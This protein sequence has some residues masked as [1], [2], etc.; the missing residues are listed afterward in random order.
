EN[1]SE[2]FKKRSWAKELTWRL[3][4][5]NQLRLKEG[6]KKSNQHYMQQIANF[7][8]FAVDK[9][10]FEEEVNAITN[11]SFPSILEGLVKGIK[12]RKTKKRSTITEGFKPEV[13]AARKTTLTYQ[14]RMHGDI[15]AFPRNQFYKESGALKDL[16]TP[17]PINL[18]REWG[19]T[20]YPQRS[21]WVDVN[22][23]DYVA[24][25]GKNIHEAEAMLSHLKEFL[26]YAVKNKPPNKKNWEV[27]CL[28]FYRGQESVI[29]GDDCA[30][31]LLSIPSIKGKV[32]SFRY[33]EDNT[34]GNYPVSIRLCSV[35]RFQGHEAD[36]VF[37]SMSNTHRD[38]FLDNPNRL[39]VAI[40]RAR[41]QLVIFGKFNYF[42][43]KSRSDDLKELAQHH[44]NF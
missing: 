22:R 38:G 19:Y 16:A 7:T 13:L 1:I 43:E 33:N 20:R 2:Y 4:R 9:E 27:A 29:R 36:V 5:E 41:F 23:K 25:R 3:G 26:A 24:K 39:N 37:L 40:T 32:S 12:G 17:T 6:N 30:D 8:P 34:L 21:M 14:H 44:T 15:S 28:A 11:M 10:K 18:T 42:A 35:D 31:G